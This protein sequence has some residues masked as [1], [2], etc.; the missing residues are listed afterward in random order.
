MKIK[1][2]KRSVLVCISVFA[3]VLALFG[4]K[5]PKQDSFSEL[6]MYVEAN[7]SSPTL[8]PPEYV[9]VGNRLAE[10]RF[11]FSVE[12]ERLKQ[13]V[14]EPY[15]MNAVLLRAHKQPLPGAY[16]MGNLNTDE[17]AQWIVKGEK[18]YCNWYYPEGRETPQYLIQEKENGALA[19]WVYECFL[20]TEFFDHKSGD[21][22][23]Y[24]KLYADAYP[25]A[26]DFSDDTTEIEK[27]LIFSND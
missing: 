14:G 17:T 26:T 6:L 18:E 4:C 11:V 3:V 9:S 5:I 15:Q 19:V 10:Y 22:E 16:D 24:Q 8:L 1:P 20:T 2:Q 25:D 27:Q 23:A 12:N 21:G 13:L 7:Y